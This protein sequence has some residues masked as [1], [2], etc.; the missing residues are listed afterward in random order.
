M[1]KPQKPSLALDLARQAAAAAKAEVQADMAPQAPAFQGWKPT[2]MQGGF[3]LDGALQTAISQVVGHF[4]K[5]LRHEGLEVGPVA[6]KPQRVPTK[7]AVTPALETPSASVQVRE[8][9]TGRVV[10][11][12]SAPALLGLFA[13]QQQRNGVVVDGQV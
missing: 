4:A 7:Q 9:G 10:R 2:E 12:Y 5:A 6:E 13:S 3:E 1:A 11:G 8:G